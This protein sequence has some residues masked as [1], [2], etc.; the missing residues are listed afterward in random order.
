MSFTFYAPVLTCFG[1]GITGE[2]SRHCQGKKTFFLCDPYLATTEAYQ[3]LKASLGGPVAGEF[4]GITPNPECSDIAAAVSLAGE[5]GAELVVG[6]GGGSA[7]DASKIVAASSLEGKNP[8]DYLTGAAQPAARLPL[9]LIPTTAGTGSEVTNVSVLCGTVDGVHV[10]KP[11][12]NNCLYADIALVDPML[13]DTMPPRVTASTGF[14]AICHALEA[15]WSRASTPISDA[16]AL[17]SVQL[18]L[19]WIGE[20]CSAS[21]S[22]EA[23]DGMA[24]AS[25]MAGI[26]F[27]QTRTTVLH[28]NSFR[29]TE[30]YGV[31]HGIACAI[32]LPG[33]LRECASSP[34]GEKLDHLARYC[35]LDD[36]RTLATRLE[37]LYRSCG[38]P[39]SLSGY[40]VERK[41]L[42][43][44]A[45]YG[46]TQA[47]T[48]LT[49]VDVTNELLISL[50]E[51]VLS[52]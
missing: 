20:A 23:R 42:P 9:V 4:S 41:D 5:R 3:T 36:A 25:V 48:A 18:A 38:L 33:F 39:T 2:L 22:H 49:P 35:G 17:Q 40:G 12:V 31:E 7:M 14:D 30:R 34:A 13:T 43:E 19:R 50:M 45:G 1:R 10:K 51:Q 37:A 29:L 32:L 46:M 28:G 52:L 11:V 16:L 24:L 44:I 8:T 6:I 15:Y 21:P 27:S 26:A 47:I